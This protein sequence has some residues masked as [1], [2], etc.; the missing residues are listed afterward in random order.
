MS[1]I[2]Q[3]SESLVQPI[4]TIGRK[5]AIVGSSAVLLKKEYGDIIDSYDTV[6][7]FNRAPVVGYE[8]FV[9]SKT[10]IRVV[11]AHV[12]TNTSCEGDERF[13]T[14]K[15][16][17]PKNFI[18]ELEN[19]TIL[20]VGTAGAGSVDPDE[21]G[22]SDRSTHIHPTSKAFIMNYNGIPISD[23]GKAPTVGIKTI[24]LMILNNLTPHLFGFGL[25]ESGVS[26][27]WEDR[28]PVSQ[29]HAYSDERNKLKQ[30]EKQVQ[31]KIFR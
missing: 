20:H 1:D 5:V 12:F 16:T 3:L 14:A 27:Y 7:R 22:W 23:L 24:K 11:N 30:W 6:I 31:I 10:D 15:L 18:K 25:D 17:Q 8:N 13:K 26:H 28:D 21:M 29:C 19:T 2:K 4:L 9:G